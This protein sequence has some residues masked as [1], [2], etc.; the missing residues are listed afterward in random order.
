MNKDTVP[1]YLTF[2]YNRFETYSNQIK[3]LMIA[4]L[5]G[6]YCAGERF[7]IGQLMQTN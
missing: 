1:L 7:G 6:P 2:F 5:Y 3:R 4:N